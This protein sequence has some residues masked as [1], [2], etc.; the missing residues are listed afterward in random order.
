MLRQAVKANEKGC[1]GQQLAAAKL[2]AV[3]RSIQVYQ[4]AGAAL[5]AAFPRM[6]ELSRKRRLRSSDY[7]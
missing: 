2:A 5:V 4:P 6:P 7:C 1:Q 3:L